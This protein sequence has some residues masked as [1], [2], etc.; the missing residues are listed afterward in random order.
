MKTKRPRFIQQENVWNE[1]AIL[2][3]KLFPMR[4][5]LAAEKEENSCEMGNLEAFDA[6]GA[7]PRRAHLLAGATKHTDS[8][9]L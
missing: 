6:P 4:L 3:Y 7:T 5:I 1:R 8:I 2:F 9:N